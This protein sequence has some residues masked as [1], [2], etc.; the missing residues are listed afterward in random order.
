MNKDI[1]ENIIKYD[2]LFSD[3][4]KIKYTIKIIAIKKIK[5]KKQDQKS[6]WPEY[7]NLDDFW[8][9]KY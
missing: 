9:L 5:Q 7:E 2:I 4:K 6:L 8:Y 1:G 3:F